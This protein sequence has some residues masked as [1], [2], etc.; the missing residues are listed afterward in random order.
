M[1][2]LASDAVFSRGLISR[3]EPCSTLL[4]KRLE[5][6]LLGMGAVA[7]RSSRGAAA[8]AGVVGRLLVLLLGRLLPRLPLSPFQPAGP[9]RWGS[10]LLK[11]PCL[12]CLD[13][14]GVT[15]G[16]GEGVRA[17]EEPGLSC[18][19]GLSAGVGG[20]PANSGSCIIGPVFSLPS[21]ISC[22]ALFFMYSG[23]VEQHGEIYV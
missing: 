3:S 20:C 22:S 14:G 18:S 12:E 4:L 8:E 13:A 19:I 6:R 16:L 9:R 7:R 10:S 15:A 21:E 17:G 5:A 2:T 11:L 1:D 23:P